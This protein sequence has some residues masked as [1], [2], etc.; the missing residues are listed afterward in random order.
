MTVAVSGQAGRVNWGRGQRCW[1]FVR[2]LLA[3]LLVA[4]SA[5]AA[6]APPDEPLS[7]FDEPAA[8]LRW[9]AVEPAGTMGSSGVSW[10]AAGPG[11]FVAT[12][13][14]YSEM[15]S[16]QGRL[17]FSA[18]GVTWDEQAPELFRRQGVGPVQATA[19]AYFVLAAPTP[20]TEGSSSQPAHLYRSVDGRTWDDL[21]EPEHQF[22]QLL[23]VAG[24][25]LGLTYD[26]SGEPSR[27][28]VSADGMTWHDVGIDVT[29]FVYSASVAERDETWY[30]SL[31]DDINAVTGSVW[32]S[33]DGSTWR[34]EPAADSWQL[35]ATD[36]A[37]LAAGAPDWE[38]PPHEPPDFRPGAGPQRSNQWECQFTP[39]LSWL[40]SS[41]S[42]WQ[43]LGSADVAT[44]PTWPMIIPF[45]NQLL[46]VALEHDGRH[47]VWSSTDGR[48]W[49]SAAA[50]VM[51]AN[52]LLSP[53]HLS[54][55]AAN[56]TTLVIA[57]PNNGVGDR[58]VL[59]VATIE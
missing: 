48:A 53:P 50:P 20:M 30:L 51:L 39:Q 14:G 47:A 44:A 3:G 16:G 32:S 52:D 17:W 28:V 21:G 54:A 46:L 58:T 10:I 41:G 45:G 56:E 12:G 55:W 15:S 36:R 24:Q 26:A 18:D 11:G 25:L 59:L 1:R 19:D 13:M 31:L 49:A 37:L 8:Q 6:A 43:A 7:L 23:G 29:S 40:A 57:G 5:T 42:A 4:G 27:V 34:A 22:N 33:T 9:Q 38:C 35:V 2:P